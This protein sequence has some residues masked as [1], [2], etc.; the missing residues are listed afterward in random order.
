MSRPVPYALL[1]ALMMLSPVTGIAAQTQAKDPAQAYPVKPIRFVIAFTPGG[2]SDILSRLVGTKLS[3]SVGQP[4]IFDNR[5]GAGGNIAGEIVAKSVPDGHT[6]M[7]ANNGVLAANATLYKKMTFSP[8]K[9]LSPVVWV[10]TQPN[11]LAVHPSV[12]VNSV[13][14][15][16][17][18]LKARPGQ[19][20]YASSGNGAAAHLSAELFKSMTHTDMVHIP[21]KGAGPALADV[22]AGN[23]QVI[24]ATA[25]SVQPY[26]QSGRLRPLA[27]TTAKRIDSLPNLPTI[28]ESG[29][30]GFDA[31]T[32]H[33]MVVPTGTPR[34]IIMRLNSEVNAILKQPDVVKLLTNQ[35]AEIQGGTPEQFGAFI[36]SE[37]P[38][39]AKVIKDAGASVD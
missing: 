39:W 2:P 18:Y 20:N 6:L 34:A 11:I 26:L 35:G 5:P 16:I 4:V 13:K 12:P 25:L 36:K 23:S 17:A 21:F 3:Q 38:K 30:P 7:I 14:E 10:A 24:F 9:E 28:S 33:G 31:S 22:L 8:G 1:C 27:V 15:L 32:W 37:G 29:V 19:L